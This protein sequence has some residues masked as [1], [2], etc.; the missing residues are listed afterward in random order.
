MVTVSGSKS[1][2]VS[3]CPSIASLNR[4][5]NVV[6]NGA[7]N[8]SATFLQKS[9]PSTALKVVGS[10]SSKATICTGVRAIFGS[11]G[12]SS[13]S[14]AGATAVATTESISGAM[15]NIAR[16]RVVRNLIVIILPKAGDRSYACL[17]YCQEWGKQ[18]LETFNAALRPQQRTARRNPRRAG[19][20]GGAE[21]AE[22]LGFTCAVTA[23]SVPATW[24]YLLWRSS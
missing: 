24:R 9:G 3:G 10:H 14:C 12:A 19:S 6:A 11:F 22:R 23:R 15:S 18:G 20:V 21:A 17:A 2:L 1:Q 7:A 16:T 13:C 8:A 5:L 4:S